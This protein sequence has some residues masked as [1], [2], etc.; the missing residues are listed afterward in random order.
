M[1]ARGR[2]AP[3][4]VPPTPRPAGENDPC[5]ICLNAFWT[6]GEAF[7]P[8]CAIA[9]NMAFVSDEVRLYCA[10][11]CVA[12]L[13]GFQEPFATWFSAVIMALYA[14]LLEVPVPLE[15]DV[16][17]VDAVGVEEDDGV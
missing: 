11:V 17:C 13:G 14:A 5:T 12:N 7:A 9:L 3:V 15:P 10:A 8:P 1:P 6:C 2:F 4:T 16:V